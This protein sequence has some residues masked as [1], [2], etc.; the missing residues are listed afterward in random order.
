MSHEK[1]IYSMF[2]KNNENNLEEMDKFIETYNLLWLNHNHIENLNIP[3]TTKE[4]EW[5]I[6][7]N[8]PNKEKYGTRS[9]RILSNF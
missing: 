2:S 6:K 1:P 8:I 5:V 4:I 7:K 9:L 3:T